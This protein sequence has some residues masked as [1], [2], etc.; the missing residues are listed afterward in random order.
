MKSEKA[1]M[2]SILRTTLRGCAGD[3]AARRDTIWE[4]ARI[5]LAGVLLETDAF[6]RERLLRGI[7]QELRDSLARLEPLLR[8][9]AR[10]PFR[11]AGDD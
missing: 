11:G 4:A 1:L 7:E 8:E 9:P 2:T 5:L 6:N 10:N 3:V